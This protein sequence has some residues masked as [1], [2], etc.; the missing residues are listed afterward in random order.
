ML[1][2]ILWGLGFALEVVILVRGLRTRMLTKYPYFY[3]YILCVS[4]ASAALFTLYRSSPTLYTK[5]YWPIELVT[6]VA[7]CGVVLEILTL[8]LESYP[9]AA[10]FLRRLCLLLF[11]VVICYGLA[12]MAFVRPVGSGSVV[13]TERELRLIEALIL[14][15]MLAVV[16]Y[17]AIRL[18]RNLKGLI[19]GY[20][21]Y[22]AVSLMTLAL[23][24]AIG[25]R[26]FKIWGSVQTAT[27]L[28]SL[29][30]WTV[31]LW[32]YDPNPGSGSGGRGGGKGPDYET[33]ALETRERLKELADQL[34][35]TKRR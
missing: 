29:A 28:F 4:V 34:E 25:H 9:G 20:G 22:I 26:F 15:A 32:S 8:G 5:F 33:L 23:Y 3:F 17:Y 2:M 1:S 27:Y 35:G 30:V 7:G 24:A 19:L 11:G 12:R 14:A 10:R 13:R 16:A 18:G 6:V 31:A 21:T